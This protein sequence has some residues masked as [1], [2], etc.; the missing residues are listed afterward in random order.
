MVPIVV[1]KLSVPVS[2]N[3]AIASIIPT[4]T[5]FPPRLQ[6][7]R[8]YHLGEDI[9]EG[10]RGMHFIRVEDQ[11]DNY[12]WNTCQMDNTGVKFS[13]WVGRDLVIDPN[14]R[15]MLLLHPV[16][17]MWLCWQNFRLFPGHTVTSIRI[18]RFPELMF[19]L[20]LGCTPG[21]AIHVTP[22]VALPD[23][24]SS[25]PPTLSLV[26]S[27]SLTFCFYPLC[28][29]VSPIHVTLHSCVSLSHFWYLQPNSLLLSS[30]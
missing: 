16:T 21:D 17:L 18:L 23:H 19:A 2:N 29:P 15:D 13:I 26:Y 28:F 1:S 10:M 4:D 20:K 3:I 14:P 25:P 8:P 27:I 22:L 6:P 5:L 30:I 7:Q 9:T 11:D 12:Y 24:G